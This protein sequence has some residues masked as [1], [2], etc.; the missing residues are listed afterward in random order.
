M[1]KSERSSRALQHRSRALRLIAFQTIDLRC[2]TTAF[3]ARVMAAAL[4]DQRRE[5]SEIPGS[6]AFQLDIATSL[7][8]AGY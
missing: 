7:Q 3:V 2:V 5:T 1:G 4:S 6:R 8:D